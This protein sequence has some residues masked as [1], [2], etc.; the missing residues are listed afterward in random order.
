LYC[1]NFH[2]LL[3]IRNKPSGS[4]IAV[5]LKLSVYTL[6][7]TVTQSNAQIIRAVETI[8]I[9]FSNEVEGKIQIC[10]N[11]LLQRALV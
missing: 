4:F 7:H 11:L 3:P 5:S 9:L 6:A 1:L 2:A 8:S 10:T